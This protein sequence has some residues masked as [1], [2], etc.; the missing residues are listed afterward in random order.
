MKRARKWWLITLAWFLAVNPASAQSGGD[1][2]AGILAG[3]T[4]SSFSF[5]GFAHGSESRLGGTAG[6]FAAIRTSWYS[7]GTAEVSWVQKGGENIRLDYI[8]V[9]VLVG[10]VLPAMDGGLRFRGYL[11]IALGFKIGCSSE[12]TYFDCDRVNSTEW[13]LPFGLM[14]GRW[15]NS[16]RFFALDVRYSLALSDVVEAF[17]MK[18]RSLQFRAVFGIPLREGG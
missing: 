11:G 7:V 4:L 15:L 10:A 5:W 1:A 14:F 18:S 13:S 6:L 16:G 3:A 12:V 17:E 9:P 2:F 8:E